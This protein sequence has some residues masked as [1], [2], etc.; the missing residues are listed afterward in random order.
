MS[1]RRSNGTVVY[2]DTRPQRRK[3]LFYFGAHLA[4]DPSW[5]MSEEGKKH[6]ETAQATK[7]CNAVFHKG[8]EVV[9]TQ[10]IRPKVEIRL[11]YEPLE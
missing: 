3:H 2:L 5:G 7:G 10:E 6:L 9:A 1:F 8:L 11:K 4:N